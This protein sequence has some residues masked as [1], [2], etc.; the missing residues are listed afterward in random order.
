ME[1]YLEQFAPSGAIVRGDETYKM[2]LLV[3]LYIYYR[4]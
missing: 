1:S 3:V 2:S 4:A